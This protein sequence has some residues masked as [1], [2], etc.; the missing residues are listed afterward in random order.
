MLAVEGRR[1]QTAANEVCAKIAVEF[2]DIAYSA[3]ISITF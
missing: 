2:G 1:S 3:R